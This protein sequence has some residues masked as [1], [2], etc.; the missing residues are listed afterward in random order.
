ML[1]ATYWG[2]YVR[3]WNLSGDLLH[4]WRTAGPVSA[5]SPAWHP[6]GKVLATCSPNDGVLRIWD[7]QSGRETRRLETKAHHWKTVAW[8]PDG[9]RL[10]ASTDA[11]LLV[12][13]PERDVIEYDRSDLSGNALACY[14]ENDN[15]HLWVSGYGNIVSRCDCEDPDTV[16]QLDLPQWGTHWMSFNPTYSRFVRGRTGGFVVYTKDGTELGEVSATHHCD[17]LSLA[18]SPDGGRWA[19]GLV[20]GSILGLNDQGELLHVFPPGRMVRALARSPRGDWLASGDDDGAVK[21]W[22]PEGDPGPVLIDDAKHIRAIAWSPDGTRLATGGA[23]RIVRVWSVQGELLHKS[24]PGKGPVVQLAWS[25]DGRQLA[26]DD[27][28]KTV[29]IWD[30]DGKRIAE[31]T[32]NT[33][34]KRILHHAG[35]EWVVARWNHLYLWDSQSPTESQLFFHTFDPIVALAS[36]AE[37]KFMAAS[38]SGELF[39]WDD[40]QKEPTLATSFGTPLTTA[41]SRSKDG[42]RGYCARLSRHSFRQL[43]RQRSPR[44]VLDHRVTG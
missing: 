21:L 35:T 23:D 37:H 26:S 39:I 18:G 42:R 6:D 16:E 14:W 41:A 43:R 19:V 5:H 9:T 38:A 27:G 4:Q 2:G 17:I 25:R 15:R 34:L 29:A 8:S 28:D 13:D 12:W 31:W 7:A 3:T 22:T 20:N 40:A 32:N 10:A 24:P 44:P 1:T 30:G 36:S 11:R 33:G